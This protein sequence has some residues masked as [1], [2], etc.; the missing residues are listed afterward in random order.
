MKILAISDLHSFYKETVKALE[1]SGHL[2]DPD[3]VVLVNGDVLDRGDE[4]FELIDYLIDLLR[5]GRLIYVK[6]N[7]EALLDE[8][9]DDIAKGFPIEVLGASRHVHNGTVDTMLKLAGMNADEAV[10]FPKELVER[11]RNSRFYKEL[12]PAAVNYYETDNYIF[13][14][15]WIPCI[16][17]GYGNERTYRYNKQWRDASKL[18]WRI[19]STLNGM[20]MAVEYGITE[21]GKT[22]VCGHF[23]TSYGHAN[24][25]R[26]CSE[27][28]DDAIYTPFYADG[29]IAIDACTAVSGRVNCVVIE[30]TVTEKNIGMDG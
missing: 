11:V 4:P 30:D 26:I 1:E 6:G 9:L 22:V 8:A 18:H 24:I 23:H 27:Y 20:K 16:I 17:E 2:D 25:S 10:M 28:G 3:S 13:T 5:Q 21:P 7:H 29:I 14:H 15:G 19:A 12:L